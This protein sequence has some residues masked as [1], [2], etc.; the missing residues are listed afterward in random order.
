VKRLCLV[1]VAGGLGTA[2]AVSDCLVESVCYND[3]DCPFSQKCDVAAGKCKPLCH[4]DSECPAGE[5]C[6]VST[7]DCR[8]A[9]CFVDG[10][11]PQG[12][13][14]REHHCYPQ[15]TVQCPMG[16]RA[17]DNRFCMDV[18]EASRPDATEFYQ[19]TDSSRAENREGVMPWQPVTLEIAREACQNAGKRLCTLEEWIIAC[20]GINDW[21]YCYGNE[22][23]PL[24]CNSIDTYCRCGPGTDCEDRD[25]C[26]FPHCYGICGASLHPT[27]TGSFPDCVNSWGIYDI[28]G[29]V[30]E[31]A[32]SGDGREHF[33]GGAYNC[34]DSERLHRC[35][36]D[37]SNISAKGF[38]CCQDPQIP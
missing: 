23:D 25:P 31:L 6:Q 16:M 30:W 33:R 38:R 36:Y 8:P 3:A 14:C 35:D 28:C 2:L 1:V 21:D 34:I 32:D 9:E 26:P 19:G 18:W 15:E 24:I 20:R 12:E 13:E 10:D 4:D 37:A 11:C 22:Y 5:Y 29:N 17:I 7:G 27:P